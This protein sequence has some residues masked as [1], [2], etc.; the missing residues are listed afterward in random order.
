MEIQ[1]IAPSNNNIWQQVWRIY[2]DSFPEHE[3][4]RISSHSAA[5]DNEQFHTQIAVENGNLMAILFFWKYDGVI[6]VEHLAVNPAMRNRN[7]GTTVLSEF[8]EANAGSSIILEIDPPIDE[9]S[10][11]RLKFYQRIGFIENTYQ[12]THPSYNRNGLEHELVIMSY[13]KA[14]QHETFDRFN[15]YMKDVVLTYID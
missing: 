10:Q 14:L 2:I 9:I 4:R 5:C 8:I 1:D 7:V 11:R 13:P 6:Y 3:R 12:Y 15:Q